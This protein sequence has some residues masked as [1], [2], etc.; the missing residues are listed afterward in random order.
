ML[1]ELS[2][3]LTTGIASLES[4]PS[5]APSRHQCSEKVEKLLQHLRAEDAQGKGMPICDSKLRL[6]DASYYSRCSAPSAPS[7]Y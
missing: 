6:A 7:R 2:T 5:I 3:A 4:S 1:K